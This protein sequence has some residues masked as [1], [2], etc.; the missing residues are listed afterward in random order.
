MYA[1]GVHGYFRHP[2]VTCFFFIDFIEADTYR[3]WAFH[4]LSIEQTKEVYK[5]TFTLL[6]LLPVTFF[7]ALHLSSIFFLIP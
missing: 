1:L 2:Y 4:I 6:K 3:N 7:L 5:T